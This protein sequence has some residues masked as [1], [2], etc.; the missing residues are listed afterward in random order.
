[1]DFV[2]WISFQTVGWL[3]VG[4]YDWARPS[5]I[6]TENPE[7]GASS[8]IWR[9]SAVLKPLAIVLQHRFR[10]KKSPAFRA[11]PSELRDID[12]FWFG[13]PCTMYISRRIPDFARF[14]ESEIAP[15]LG[16]QNSEMRKYFYKRFSL[17]QSYV[18]GQLRFK[19]LFESNAWARSTIQSRPKLYFWH[20]RYLQ[21]EGSSSTDWE[22]E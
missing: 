8:S 5:T 2:V 9:P 3:L 15:G 19:I 17:H 16:P 6:P 20:S 4:W 18:Q 12:N 14:F 13:T 21:R 10:N 7:V 11:T 22:R 1:M